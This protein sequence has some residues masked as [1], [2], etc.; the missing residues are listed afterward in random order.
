MA[1]EDS[2]NGMAAALGAG[3]SCVVTTS[4]YTGAEDFTGAALVVTTLGDPASAGREEVETEV[5]ADPFGISP[6]RQIELDDLRAV[7]SRAHTPPYTPTPERP[8]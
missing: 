6:G 7:L 2:A 3:M 4:S 8:R 5:L 1:I